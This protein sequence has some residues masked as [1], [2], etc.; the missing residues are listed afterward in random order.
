MIA[1][2]HAKGQ[3]HFK[4]PPAEYA[5]RATMQD[6]YGN[7]QWRKVLLKLSK[8]MLIG[9]VKPE[10]FP[11]LTFPDDDAQVDST[12]VSCIPATL[13]AYIELAVRVSRV[14]LYFNICM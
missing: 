12:T 10:D 2:V 5:Y 4:T 8:L 13:M 9:G 3:V 1:V 7:K 6:P 11:R 14:I